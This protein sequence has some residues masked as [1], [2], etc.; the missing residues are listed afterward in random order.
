MTKTNTDDRNIT[1]IAAL[2][3]RGLDTFANQIA[4]AGPEGLTYEITDGTSVAWLD[5]QG[6]VVVVG[7]RVS[8]SEKGWE[9]ML[10][11]SVLEAQIAWAG[12]CADAVRAG[13]PGRATWA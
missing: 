5:E 12:R 7:D 10:C 3:E 2:L 1:M 13:N 4:D 8:L 11:Y 9:V 6:L